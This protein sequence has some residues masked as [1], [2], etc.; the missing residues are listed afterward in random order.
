M[1]EPLTLARLSA[2][3]GV[4]PRTIRSWVAEQ[5][6]PGPLARGRGATYPPEAIV[7]VRQVRRM[8]EANR[9]AEEI[10]RALV[11]GDDEFTQASLSVTQFATRRSRR[12]ASR[13]RVRGAIMESLSDIPIPMFHSGFASLAQQ[14]GAGDAYDPNAAARSSDWVSFE[15]SPDVELRVR[16]PI[17]EDQ[18]ALIA[19]CATA[20]GRILTNARAPQGADDSDYS[21]E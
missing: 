13:P 21:P 12:P 14:L 1:T 5:L 7:R 16:G 4:S 8:R 20:I 19:R 15:V 6:V 3:T 11:F 18:R 10:R 17:V 9:S 2:E